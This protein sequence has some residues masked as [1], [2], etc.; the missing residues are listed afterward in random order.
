[1]S[2]FYN[3]G[4][5]IPFQDEF[6]FSGFFDFLSEGLCPIYSILF[7]Q[8]DKYTLPNGTFQMANFKHSLVLLCLLSSHFSLSLSLYKSGPSRTW[9][10]PCINV[11]GGNA[12]TQL[13]GLKEGIVSTCSN[14]VCFNYSDI[15]IKEKVGY[16]RSLLVR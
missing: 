1:M 8:S 5:K 12:H 13:V 3:K 10:L 14:M 11:A 6:S 7:A 2:F 15:R 9:K 16:S 4:M